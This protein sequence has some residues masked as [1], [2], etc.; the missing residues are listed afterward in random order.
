M[1][2]DLMFGHSGSQWL[3]YLRDNIPTSFGKRHLNSLNK[4]YKKNPQGCLQTHLVQFLKNS[5]T[6]RNNCTCFSLIFTKFI[7]MLFRLKKDVNQRAGYPLLK[8]DPFLVYHEHANTNISEFVSDVLDNSTV[9]DVEEWK[10]K[11]RKNF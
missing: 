11:E 3:K 10:K 9:E 1:M 6:K 7:F 8:Q 2:F 5:L 4:S